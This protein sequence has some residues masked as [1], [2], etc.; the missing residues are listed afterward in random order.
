MLTGALALAAVPIVVI[1]LTA[2]FLTAILVLISVFFVK[3]FIVGLIPLWSLTY[4]Y[5]VLLHL[6]GSFTLS[7]FFTLFVFTDFILTDAPHYF[8]T[9]SQR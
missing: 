8:S 7:V 6:L 9:K 2:S 4:N 3:L 5:F 1:L